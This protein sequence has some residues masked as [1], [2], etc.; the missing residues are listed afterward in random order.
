MKSI[1]YL[2]LFL[3]FVVY[4]D[5]VKSTSYNSNGQTGLIALPSAEVH[6]QQSIFFTLNKNS[7][8]K[9]G[10]LTVTPFDWMEASFF[11]YRP[12]DLIWGDTP[13]LYLDKGFNV[14]FSYKPKS[15]LLPRI[16]IG[17]DDFAGTGQFTKEYIVS[18]YDFNNIKLSTGVG[19]GKFVGDSPQDNPLDFIHSRFNIRPANSS[20]NDNYGGN[21]SSNTWFRGDVQYFA[22]IELKSNIIKGISYKLE[23][24]PYN[25][26]EYM[27]C[28]EGT[29]IMS[30]TVRKKESD[31]NFGISY[32]LKDYGNIDL[33]FTQG[34]AWNISF[35]VG[36]SSKNPIRKKN[37]FLPK[38]QNNQNNQ[39]EIRNEFYWD[40]LDNLNA[41]NLF[42]QTASLNGDKLKLTIDS[43]EHFNPIIYTSRSALI[44]KEVSKNN[45]ID[46]K[47]IEVGNI[48]RG[49]QI[50]NI[51][52]RT[53]D[54]NLN[55]RYPDVL[56][57]KYSQVKQPNPKDYISSDFKP[58]V[59]FPLFFYNI[60]PDVRTHVGSPQKVVFTGFGVK[61]I[62]EVQFN[63]NITLSINIAKSLQDNFDNKFSDPNSS[64]E[65]VRTEILDYLQQTGDDLY[66]NYLD[67]DSIWSP[68][69]G[70][71]T[72][73]QFGYLEPMYGGVSSEFLYKPFESNFAVSAEFNK[74]KKRFY[75]QKFSFLDYKTTTSHLN[76][77]YYEPNTNILA[78]L[79]FGK[80]LAGDSGYTL[81]LSRRMPSGWRAGFFFTRTNVSA[82]EFGEGSFDKGFYFNIPFNIFS[83][84][85]SKE[86]AGLQFRTMTRD[87]GQKLELR[88]KLI[89]SFY[90]SSLDE[91]NEN[92]ENFLDW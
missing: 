66:I 38:L 5:I 85:Y 84:G 70:F 59:N 77:A 2:C 47:T 57:E 42:L 32:K 39:I 21:L 46:I 6:D 17:L 34:N 1:N 23:T 3:I 48:V 76:I 68:L 20:K 51:R 24:N 25:Y 80:Y 60:S 92:W 72:K 30:N 27:C 78:K 52:Y 9:I 11:Y 14:K 74:V 64:M 69:K 71:W 13:G 63:R 36:F 88:N 73:F 58:R 4:T 37:K 16:A 45:K 67:I 62:S 61:A 55:K 56:I 53:Q 91:I 41:N 79:S 26:F 43:K 19:W 40:L 75:D 10:T 18:T 83:K 54:L 87:G 8:Y 50:N 28:G 33:S 35:S 81:D 7:Y 12:D 90:G 15:F 49:A 89:D 29:S 86:S 65:L 22:G 31:L 44:A 82:E